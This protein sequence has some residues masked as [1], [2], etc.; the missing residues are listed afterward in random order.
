MAEI[1]FYFFDAIF[2]LDCVELA[3][4]SFQNLLMCFQ[5]YICHEGDLMKAFCYK[6]SHNVTDI[7][8][9]F[10]SSKKCNYVCFS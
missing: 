8:V 4:E 6:L 1:N 10:F 7:S 9:Y 5:I 3:H 2:V